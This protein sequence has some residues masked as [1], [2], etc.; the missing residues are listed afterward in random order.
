MGFNFLYIY[1]NIIVV[2]IPPVCF[3]LKK[4]LEVGYKVM[5]EEKKGFSLLYPH[6]S[7]IQ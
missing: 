4:N 6:I 5:I 1:L 2:L 3:L 7:L